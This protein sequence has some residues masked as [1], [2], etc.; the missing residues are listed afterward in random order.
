MFFILAND[1][2][3]SFVNRITAISHCTNNNVGT[4]VW[5]DHGGGFGQNCMIIANILSIPQQLLEG[6]VA[7]I[8]LQNYAAVRHSTIHLRIMLAMM[9]VGTLQHQKEIRIGP[10][11]SILK[12]S[13]E[14][15]QVG[16]PIDFGIFLDLRC[17]N[18]SFCQYT[19]TFEASL[20]VIRIHT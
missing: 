2:V 1:G 3:S 12:I 19:L 11:I 8:T 13:M 7:P 14:I 20:E 5:L 6:I 17:W 9:S 16:H 18:E 4:H 15:R 10:N